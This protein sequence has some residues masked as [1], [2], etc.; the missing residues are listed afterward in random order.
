VLGQLGIKG[1]Q[2]D[3]V[4]AAEWYLKAGKAGDPEH[5]ERLDGLRRWLSNAP[6]L[7]EIEATTLQQLLR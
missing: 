1:F 2:A 7:G 5:T 3:P 6:S 4:K